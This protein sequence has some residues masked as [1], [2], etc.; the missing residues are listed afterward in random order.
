MGQGRRFVVRIRFDL[1]AMAI[2]NLAKVAFLVQQPDTHQWHI[3]VAGSFHMVPSQNSEAPSIQRQGLPHPELHTEIGHRVEQVG[4][5]GLP[6]PSLSLQIISI[7]TEQAPQ[8]ASIAP[9]SGK[10][11]KSLLRN[12]VQD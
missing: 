6:K 7:G 8:F 9:A 11:F 4:G 1:P 2:E 10:L 12:G 3:E 5:M